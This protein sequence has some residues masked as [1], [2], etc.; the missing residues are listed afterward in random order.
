MDS[1]AYDFTIPKQGYSDQEIESQ[2][3]GFLGLDPDYLHGS[4]A[5]YCM[6]GTDELQRVLKDAYLKFF[7]QNGIVRRMMPGT[8]QLE[9]EMHS[10][11]A[12]ILSGGVPGVVVNFT[13]G[14]TESIFCGLHAAREWAREAHPDISA[15]EFIVPYSAHPAFTKAAHYLGLKLLRVPLG[16]DLRAD[17]DAIEAMIGSN[18][19]GLAGSAPTW[20]H[21]LYDPIGNLGQIADRHNIWMHVDAC[22][23]GY[24]AP[25]VKL[26]GYPVPEWDFNVPGVMSISADVHKYG[27]S[28]KSL[29]T[30]AW[31]SQELQ[32]FHYLS[33][34]EWPGSPYS[35]EGF[36]GSRSVGPI[37]GAWA[38]FHHL[39]EAGFIEYARQTMKN[40]LRLLDG[41]GQI[42]GLVPF[43]NDLCLA[44]YGSDD[45]GVKVEQIVGGM[46]ERGWASFGT[47]EPA[48]VQ[49]VMDPFPEDSP[50][51]DTYLQDLVAVIKDIRA[52]RN[53]RSE[54][55][56]YAD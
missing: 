20:P 19:I 23:G 21:G 38:V 22:V 48:L 26:A 46:A 34:E 5:C 36:V 2:L 8:R 9:Q 51:I 44:F 35:T 14:G 33:V 1:K 4:M 13:S 56:L 42:P 40:K 31:R 24:Q 50:I 29:S 10:M 25:F 17:C 54:G 49:L 15:P 55:L 45:P 30:I 41:V 6:K 32:R 53:V 28:A 16:A 12:A 37:S 3:N 43:E 11:C 39:G 7:H 18:T 47:V 27:Y 52:G